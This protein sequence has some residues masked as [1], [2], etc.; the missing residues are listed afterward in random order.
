MLLE[1]VEELLGPVW[2]QKLLNKKIG[3]VAGQ[4]LDADVLF[5]VISSVH[6][7]KGFSKQQAIAPNCWN[8][9]Y[10]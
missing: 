2:S 9:L 4:A 8:S 10:G 5:S 6:A 3:S 1:K 7:D